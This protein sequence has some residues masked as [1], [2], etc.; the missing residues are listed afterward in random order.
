MLC[1]VSGASQECYYDSEKVIDLLTNGVKLSVTLKNEDLQ[2]SRSDR[3]LGFSG[4]LRTGDL[5]CSYVHPPIPDKIKALQLDKDKERDITLM[6]NPY[7]KEF[8]IEPDVK[9]AC[10]IL[11]NQDSTGK[12]VDQFY[13]FA[14][15]T[16]QTLK[17]QGFFVQVSVPHCKDLER[18]QN[19]NYE[20]PQKGR[21][22]SGIAL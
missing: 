17:T 2:L 16:I 1:K 18:I 8:L 21:E 4:I 3:Q 9:V 7:T 5:H 6:V 14:P 10:F 15:V 20:S 12:I 11:S 22:S 19:I 13:R